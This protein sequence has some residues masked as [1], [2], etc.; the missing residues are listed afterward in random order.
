VSDSA[1]IVV[2]DASIGVKWAVTEREEGTGDAMWLLERHAHGDIV[3][4]VPGTFR[5]EWLNALL[6][7]GLSVPNV[8]S[9]AHDL[10][11][12]TLDWYEID[13]TL[14]LEAVALASTHAVT[15]YDA[16]Y[17]ALAN[18]LNAGLVTADA[19]LARAAGERLVHVVDFKPEP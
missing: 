8:L 3:L 18:R 7:R 1:P 4:A 15:V 16:A 2:V 10:E 12:S 5:L 6:S 17:L 11:L 13:E 14:S 9:A 19:A